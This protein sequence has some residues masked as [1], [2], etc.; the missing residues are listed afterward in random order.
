V[1]FTI[2]KLRKLLA[3]EPFLYNVVHQPNPAAKEQWTLQVP[4]V[5]R[6]YRGLA[7]IDADRVN[8]ELF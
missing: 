6:A 4:A 8:G 7:M 5:L 1:T 3:H 2:P